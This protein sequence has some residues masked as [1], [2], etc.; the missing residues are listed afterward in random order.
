MAK[1]F[2]KAGHNVLYWTSDFSHASKDK[3]LL[4]C[5]VDDGFSVRMVPTSPYPKN[6]CLKRISSHRRLAHDWY[7]MACKETDKPD[8]VIASAPPL[9]LCEAARMFA[10]E[11]GA[12][13]V[14]DV[15][16]AWPETFERVLP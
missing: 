9:G 1:A 10:K 14:A 4:V 2:V 5:K 6:I 7:E 3:R 15:Q 11:S 8:V 12:M 16:D 13:F